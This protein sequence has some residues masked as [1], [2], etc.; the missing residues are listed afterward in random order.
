MKLK[1][2]KMGLYCVSFLLLSVVSRA[3]AEEGHVGEIRYSLLTPEQFQGSYGKEWELM[4][5]QAIP[6]DS[7]LLPLFG[8]PTVPDARGIFLRCSNEGR[9]RETGNPEGDLRVGMHQAD[10]FKSHDH[11]GKTGDDSPDHTHNHSWP[12]EYGNG[13]FARGDRAGAIWHGGQTRGASVKHQHQIEAEGGEETRPRCI[14]VNAFVKMRE[15]APE[16]SAGVP[17]VTPL[18]MREITD[19]EDFSKTVEKIVRDLVSHRRI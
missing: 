10:T 12:G 7:E 11:S 9:N 1:S 16:P 15:S 2:K 6:H 3:Q 18:M 4:K 8:L 17:T 14:T 5:G 13:G 19:H